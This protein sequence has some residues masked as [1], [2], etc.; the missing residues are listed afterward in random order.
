MRIFS[1]TQKPW[2]NYRPETLTVKHCRPGDNKRRDYKIFGG[3][4]MH[5]KMKRLILRR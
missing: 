1:R 4:K 5:S 3:P 2:S